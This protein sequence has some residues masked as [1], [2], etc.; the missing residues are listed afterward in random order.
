MPTRLCA[1][2]LNPDTLYLQYLMFMPLFCLIFVFFFVWCGTITSMLPAVY[3]PLCPWEGRLEEESVC[4]CEREN[5]G[6]L[7]I[8]F[9]CHTV[10]FLL[11]CTCDTQWEDIRERPLLVVKLQ[12]K[13]WR[14]T[15]IGKVKKHWQLDSFHI[16][17]WRSGGLASLSRSASADEASPADELPVSTPAMETEISS[18]K[19]CWWRWCGWWQCPFGKDY[20]PG[21]FDLWCQG[22]KPGDNELGGSQWY[23]SLWENIFFIHNYLYFHEM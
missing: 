20:Q 21:G 19:A 23:P 2:H 10:I 9:T 6:E 13:G 12:E 18:W 14:P 22:L 3:F 1:G 7:S 11:L 15:G 5:D 17:V 8:G 4:V 16:H